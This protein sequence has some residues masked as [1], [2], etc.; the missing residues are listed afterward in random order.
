[1]KHIWHRLQKSFTSPFWVISFPYTWLIL[2]FLIPFLIVLKISFSD[3]KLGLPPYGSLTEWLD[4]GV[5]IIKLN[6]TNYGFI[7]TDS[8]YLFTYLDSLLIAIIGTIACLCIG[9]PMAY[10]IAKATPSLRTILLM[11]VILPFWTSFLLRVYAWIGIL[12]PQGFLNT[13]LIKIGIISAPLPLLDTTFATILGITYCYLPFMI[14][15]LFSSLEKIDHALVEA[16]YDLGARP[17]QA[18]IR[19]IWP[20][21]MPGVIAGSMLVF[22][23]AVGEFVIPELLGGS[24]T[25]MVGKVI[26]NEFFTNR[27]WPVAS[28]LAVLMLILLITPIAIFQR[29]QERQMR[30]LDAT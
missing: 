28:A 14:L 29:L 6:L 16:A 3:L 11:M 26:W 22:I 23:P 9:Y 7:G 27:D 8:L 17:F 1:M 20:L 5:L 15:P 30:F 4:D 18:F 19:V 2:F 21:S 12:S 13:A 25:L 24:Q 10:G